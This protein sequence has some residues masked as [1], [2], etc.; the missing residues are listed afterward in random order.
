MTNDEPGKPKNPR[1]GA[2]FWV[3]AGAFVCVI[4]AL[5]LH[6][7]KVDV[8]GLLRFPDRLAAFPT[9]EADYKRIYDA[10]LGAT[11]DVWLGESVYDFPPTLMRQD[12][13]HCIRAEVSWTYGTNRSF[14]EVRA[15]YRKALSFLGWEDD[16]EISG[17]STDRLR[18][19]LYQIDPSSPDYR[20]GKGLYQII[21]T[22]DVT[23][24]DPAIQYCI[25]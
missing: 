16:M 5:L 24:A 25:G 21:Y 3:A 8:D 23:Y 10:V 20:V 6:I 11:Q 14:D 4:I 18:I 12:P 9:V 13:V 17:V 22:I 15:D 2:W 1:L 19:R 7:F